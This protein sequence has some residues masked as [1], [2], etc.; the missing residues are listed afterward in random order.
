MN[1]TKGNKR[2]RFF[3]LLIAGALSAASLS[4]QAQNRTIKGCITDAN[5]KE[6]LMG[7]TITLDGGKT[8]AVTDL[9]K[10]KAA[11][12]SHT[13][14]VM[15][16]LKDNGIDVEWIQIGNETRTGML[17]PLGKVSN[18][19]FATDDCLA[20]I[21]TLA[22]RYNCKVMVSEIGMPWD[23]ENAA[24]MMKKMVDGCKAKPECLGIFY[25]E[26]ECYGGWNGYSKGA[27]SSEGKPT[28]ALKAFKN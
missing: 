26:P 13:T 2:S 9:D 24:A 22:R 18:N 5:N 28:E 8:G 23:S 27:F 17:W 4:A 6:P 12:A 19:N 1:Q 16:A 3:A 11:V 20:N 10:M 25:W 7:A 15:Q 21:S 14:D